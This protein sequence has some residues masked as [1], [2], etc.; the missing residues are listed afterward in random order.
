MDKNSWNVYLVR[1]SDNS[2]YCGITN[3]L[4]KRLAA[5][6]SGKGAKYT[7]S[8]R[9]V[10]LVVVSRSMTK[11]EALKLEYRIK[12]VAAGKKICELTTEEANMAKD[13][14]KELQLVSKEIKA[15]S[16]KIDKLVVAAGKAAK[17]KPKIAKKAKPAKKAAPKAK[18]TAVKKAPAKKAPAKNAAAKKAPAKKAA[19]KKAPAKKAA[20]V[21]AADR[22]LKVINRTKKGVD[23]SGLMKKTGFDNKKVANII[24]KLKKQ[25]K[26]KNPEKGL[27]V[28]A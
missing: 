10:V 17:A 20:K 8:R 27:Y 9:P 22:V 4:A 7:R 19:A 13:L 25:G 3:H 24:F 14:K 26:I 12:Q 16:K 5:H 2:L 28:K 23:T 21:T 15:L 11:S 6:N 18:K 1:C